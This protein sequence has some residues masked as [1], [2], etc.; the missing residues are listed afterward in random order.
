M[1]FLTESESKIGKA[2]SSNVTEK[3]TYE[4]KTAT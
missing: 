2:S 1:V 4:L 3:Q